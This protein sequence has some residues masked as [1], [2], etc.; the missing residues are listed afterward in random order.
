MELQIMAKTPKWNGPQGSDD[1]EK[2]KLRKDDS[3]LGY[4]AP[5]DISNRVDPSWKRTDGFAA[6][7]DKG[8][9]ES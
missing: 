3:A 6:K 1:M 9:K 8:P 5:K 2:D 7:L 4:H